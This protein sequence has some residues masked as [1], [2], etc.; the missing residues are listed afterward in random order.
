VRGR[1]FFLALGA[2]LTV[3]TLA[4]GSVPA[5]V[6][7]ASSRSASIRMRA[8]LHVRTRLTSRRQEDKAVAARY[9][10]QHIVIIDKENRSFDQM[11]GTF[12]GA[13]GATTARLPS[14]TVVPLGRTPDHTLLDVGH[15]GDSAAFAENQGRMNRFSE[16]PG[17]I[18]DG[19]DIAD[20]QFRQS[21]IPSYWKYAQAY[22]L[23]D[24]FFSTIDG[25]S[26]PNHL[27]TIAASSDN[28]IDNP[29][30]QTHHAWGC[31]GGPYS[32]VNAIDPATGR[33]YLTRSC[34]SIPTIANT[35]ER[36]H[37]S[38]RYFAPGQYQSGY[39]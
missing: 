27:V 10:I 16:L 23:D 29:Y 36:Y 4:L 17:A 14:G 11:F 32:V 38:W 19:R 6:G 8:A 33:H 5:I 9:P 39:V 18:Q 31:D 1:R 28:T 2:I 22:T 13:D 7:L 34:F 30:G 26:F 35:F 20:S 15:A 25:P 37:I 3:A 24:H 21:D 12:P